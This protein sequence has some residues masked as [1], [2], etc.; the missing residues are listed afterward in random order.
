MGHFLSQFMTI[1]ATLERR[2]R[3]RNYYILLMACFASLVPFCIPRRGR[4][5]GRG[6]HGTFHLLLLLLL[7]VPLPSF[8][9]SLS[10][11]SSLFLNWLEQ[12][13]FRWEFL[14]CV[15]ALRKIHASEAAV[16]VDL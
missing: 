12:T 5:R 1:E 11:S 3:E 16:G 8:L 14:L 7:L 6:L 2:R 13:E 15:L 10:S 9:L 4:G